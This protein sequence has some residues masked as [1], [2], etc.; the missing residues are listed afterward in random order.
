MKWSEKTWAETAHIYCS[1]VEMPFI[2]ELADGSLPREKFLFYI[3]QDDIYLLAY[4]RALAMIAA[5]ATT[6]AEVAAFTKFAGSA[7]VSE[8]TMHETFFED[9]EDIDELNKSAAGVPTEIQPA[10]HHYTSYLLSVAAIE[11]V[12]VAM[13]AV[14]PCFRI[15]REVGAHIYKNSAKGN[16]YQA[17]IDTYVGEEFDAQVDQ[18]MALCDAAAERTTPEMRE[19]MTAA[20][21]YAARL[22]YDFWNAGYFLRKW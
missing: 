14:L 4:A 15:Y 20:Y 5:R 18:A 7:L 8:Q 2:K 1:I 17:W 10:C 6:P 12:E 3:A 19:R 9:V 11:P 16:P 22:E 13:A 21:A